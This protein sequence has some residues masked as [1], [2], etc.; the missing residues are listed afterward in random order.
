MHPVKH[1]CHGEQVAVLETDNIPLV[2]GRGF[3]GIYVGEE[4]EGK[5]YYAHVDPGERHG[6]VYDGGHELGFVLGFDEGASEGHE[7]VAGV[8]DDQDHG[9][10]GDFVAH[11]R[12]EDE[13]GCHE[14]VKQVLVE[15]PFRLAL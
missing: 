9:A 10:C 8:V 5:D 15:L 14:V 7:Y 3:V 2:V 4:A 13:S 11:H 12:K 6:D 1:E